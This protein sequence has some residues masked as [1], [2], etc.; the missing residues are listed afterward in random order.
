VTGSLEVPP[1][2]RARRNVAQRG[3]ALDLLRSLPPEYSPLAF[4]DPQRRDVLD[5]LKFGNEGARQRGRARLPPMSEDYIDDCCR[6]I[7]R[8]LTPGGYL[9]RWMD[10]FGVCEAQHLHLTTGLKA[11]DFEPFNLKSVDLIA[12]DSLRI[13]MGKRTRRRGD[14]LLVMQK[15]PISARNWKDKA[16]PSRWPEKIDRPRSAHPHAKPIGSSQD[17]SPRSPSLAISSSIPPPAPSWRYERPF[18][19]AGILL[20]AIVNGE[21][22]SANRLSA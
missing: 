12:W 17:S 14:Y 15:P 21:S 8:V 22:P 10:T 11:F 6:E 7:A 2:V 16:I 19:S 1:V 4:F 3:E 20:A 13:G 18:N 9:L 5:R